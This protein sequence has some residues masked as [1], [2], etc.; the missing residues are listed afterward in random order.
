MIAWLGFFRSTRK[1]SARRTRGTAFRRTRKNVDPPRVFPGTFSIQLPKNW[2]LAPGHT[3]TV[4]TIVEKTGRLDVGA[5]ITLE[6]LRLQA[7]LDPALM[8]AA[9]EW[10]LREVQARELSGKN[11]TSEAKN[12][13]AGPFV[14]TQYD[15]PGLLG[16]YDHV[17]QDRAAGRHDD[18]P[19][20]L[21]CAFGDARAVQG[22]L[23]PCR[24]VVHTGEARWLTTAPPYSRRGMPRLGKGGLAAR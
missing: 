5:L 17:V 20:G 24:R 4:F 14:L 7:P 12:A 3:G 22:A 15:R 8:A 11:F 21:C 1:P 19:A 18:V 23:R 9:S 6:Y 16:S 2:Q 13:P 10:E